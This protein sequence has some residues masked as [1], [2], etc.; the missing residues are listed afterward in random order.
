[1]DEKI[2]Q[3]SSPLIFVLMVHLRDWPEKMTRYSSLHYA[4]ANIIFDDDVC[5]PPHYPENRHPEDINKLH[6]VDGRM[7]DHLYL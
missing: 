5:D 3:R 2:N 4:T 1:M 6:L 7:Y